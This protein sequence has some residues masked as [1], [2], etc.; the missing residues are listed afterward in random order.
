MI[1]QTMND[2]TNHFQSLLIKKN[3]NAFVI[4]SL[5]LGS[6]KASGNSGK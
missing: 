2:A 6:A 3:N 4:D 1:N 5:G